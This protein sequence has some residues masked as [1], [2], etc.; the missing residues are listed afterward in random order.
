MPTRIERCKCG[1]SEVRITITRHRSRR[2]QR[3]HFLFK[4]RYE[5]RYRVRGI[6][7]CAGGGVAIAYGS[8]FIIAAVTVATISFTV[9]QVAGGFLMSIS[10]RTLAGVLRAWYASVAIGQI[11]RVERRGQSRKHAE[12]QT[13]ITLA[14]TSLWNLL[15]L[16]MLIGWRAQPDFVFLWVAMVIALSGLACLHL[17]ALRGWVRSAERPSDD[18]ARRARRSL[19]YFAV[20]L[21][22][23]LA[24]GAYVLR[25]H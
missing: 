15:T 9:G 2:C 21:L 1:D 13:A 6:C 11:E 24:V 25:A 14:M 18:Y 17:T 12:T 16:L 23:F 10:I 20:S 8:P 5:R 19:A 7:R 3:C 4:W 22:G